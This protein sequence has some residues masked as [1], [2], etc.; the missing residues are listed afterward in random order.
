MRQ[1]VYTGLLLIMTLRFTSEETKIYSTIKKSQN[2]INMILGKKFNNND[3]K[4]QEIFS[5]PYVVANK[6]RKSYRGMVK[7]SEKI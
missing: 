6:F 5:N 4:L 1:L 3:V 2:I 7:I